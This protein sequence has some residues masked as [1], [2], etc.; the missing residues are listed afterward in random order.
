MELKNLREY[1]EYMMQPQRRSSKKSRF[2]FDTTADERLIFY[3][4]SKYRSD[5]YNKVFTTQNAML[6]YDKNGNPIRTRDFSGDHIVTFDDIKGELDSFMIED[7]L[8]PSEIVGAKGDLLLTNSLYLAKIKVRPHLRG[9]GIASRLISDFEKY[10]DANDYQK[11]YGHGCAFDATYPQVRTQEDDK[12]IKEIMARH[13]ITRLSED[14]KNLLLFYTKKGFHID[15]DINLNWNG[16]EHPFAFI[17][18]TPHTGMSKNE[19]LYFK[20]SKNR[21]DK[22]QILLR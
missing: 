20:D 8:T 13:H 7:S 11:I 15:N 6:V 21:L 16:V 5:L 10:A 18:K 17:K 14:D 3:L 4:K 19:M 2:K 22:D 1:I 12:L 9:Q